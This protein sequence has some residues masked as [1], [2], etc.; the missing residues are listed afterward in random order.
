MHGARRPVARIALIGIGAVIAIGGIAIAFEHY[1]IIPIA[2]H[3][4]EQRLVFRLD[5]PYGSVDLRAGAG[6]NNVATVELLNEDADPHSSPNWSYNV[7]NGNMGVL[8]IGIGTDEGMNA[9]P[10]LAMWEAR[11]GFS[12]AS[13]IAPEPDWGA[14][15]HPSLL[16]FSMPTIPN[17]AVWY[18]R[19]R[20]ISTDAG[21]HLIPE[22][23]AGTRI[24]LA[25]DL[26]ID[27]GADLGFGES[28]LDLSGLPI[29]DASIE[30]GAS[31]AHIY[32]NVPNPVPMHNC[33][34]RAGLGQSNFNGIS[35]LNADRFTFHGGLGSYQLGFEGKLTH[36]LYAVVDIGIG[37]CTLSI[38]P[39]AGRVQVFC[40]DG[41]LSS[42]SFSGLVERRD[43]YWSSPGFELSRSPVITL[44]LSSGAG[45]ISVSYH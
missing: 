35:N 45:K 2:R 4:G 19:M 10:P 33:T 37:M 13:A 11:S 18:G 29:T 25:K 26:P 8:N 7:R 36:N 9:G 43:G 20:S 5:A 38:P 17:G 16:S 28:T 22:A 1:T 21:T 30:T 24:T 42:Y 40:E 14:G 12:P 27:F 34:V 3:G 44:R 32:C 15:R 41:F 39:T 31:K 23:R 6:P